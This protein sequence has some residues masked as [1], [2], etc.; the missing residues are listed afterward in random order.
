MVDIVTVDSV[1]ARWTRVPDWI[2]LDVRGLELDVLE[3][4]REVIRA[5]RGR[6]KIIA[7]MHPQL[8][9][10]YGIQPRE[11]DERLAALS[12][13]AR[14]LTPDDSLLTPDSHMILEPL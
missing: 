6:L 10:E 9:P 5:G 4:A 11:V 12:L 2:R 14:G 3:G 8:W 1:C 7:E 13:Q